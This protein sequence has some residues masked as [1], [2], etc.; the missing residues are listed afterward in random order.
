MPSKA[1]SIPI[2][3]LSAFTLG[4]DLESRKQAARE[5]AE[6]SHQ[7]GSV[8]ICGHGVP[9]DMLEKAFQIMQKLFGLSHEDK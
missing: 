9:A 2:V 8:G 6:K 5:L 3:D 4:G 7:N 1:P